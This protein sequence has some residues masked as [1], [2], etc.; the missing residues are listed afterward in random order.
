MTT[1]TSIPR[2]NK[3]ISKPVIET[4][5]EKLMKKLHGGAECRVA[6]WTLQKLSMRDDFVNA[7]TGLVSHPTFTNGEILTLHFNVS[8]NEDPSKADL[9]VETRAKLE[10]NEYDIDLAP[11]DRQVGLIL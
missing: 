4:E 2:V 5:Y 6:G 3:P 10:L 1:I 7:F 8:P 11:I 9:L